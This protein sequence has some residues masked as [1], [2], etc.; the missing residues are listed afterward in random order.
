MFTNQSARLSS[1]FKDRKTRSIIYINRCTLHLSD[2]RVKTLPFIGCELT[3]KY[4]ITR[5]RTNVRDETV[6]K[7]YVVHLKREESYWLTIINSYILSNTKRKRGLT[8]GRTSC[9]N[10]QI[11]R[12]PTSCNLI[13]VVETT[14]NSCQFIFTTCCFEQ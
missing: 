5:N 1:K 6:N 14:W 2:I 7:L 9:Y 8:H 11:R 10:N 12:L 4:L 13:Q 3:I